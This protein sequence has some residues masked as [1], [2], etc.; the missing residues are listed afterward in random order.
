MGRINLQVVV[1]RPK[2]LLQIGTQAWLAK[3]PS[4]VLDE[5]YDI[6]G[7]EAATLTVAQR[8]GLEVPEHRLQTLSTGA[9]P[10]RV[11]LVRR[12]DVLGADSG[13]RAHMASLRTLCR[14]RPGAEALSYGELAAVVRKTSATPARDVE[15]LFRHMVFNAAVGNTDDHLKNFWMLHTETGWALA[16]AIDLLPDVGQRREHTLSFDQFTVHPTRRALLDAAAH[17]GVGAAASLIDQVCAAVAQ[18]SR[19]AESFQVQPHSIEV[20]GRDIA[21]RLALLA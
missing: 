16:P 21:R 6:V 10:D 13:G 11:L 4:A 17:W 2:A 7:L 18:W 20:C 15:A 8:A 9:H 19:V 1:T 5:G 14:E 12:F 3:F